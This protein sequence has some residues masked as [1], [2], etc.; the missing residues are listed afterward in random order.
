MQIYA[1]FLIVFPELR[2]K[3]ALTFGADWSGIIGSFILSFK[4]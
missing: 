1:N 4:F 3:Y 2:H